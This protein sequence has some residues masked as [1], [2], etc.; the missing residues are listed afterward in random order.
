M[1]DELLNLTLWESKGIETHTLAEKVALKM[2]CGGIES[3]FILCQK[4]QI[5]MHMSEKI[6]LFMY[7]AHRYKMTIM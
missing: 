7:I 4:F 6:V 1:E 3:A 5:I 2:R